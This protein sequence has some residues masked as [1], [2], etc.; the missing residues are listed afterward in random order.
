MG[1]PLSGFL[2]GQLLEFLEFV[3]FKYR[4][5]INTTYF[6]YIVDILIFLPQNITIEKIAEDWN[7]IEASTNFTYEKES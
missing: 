7:N 5:P 6:R 1:N 2:A 3:P 4:L